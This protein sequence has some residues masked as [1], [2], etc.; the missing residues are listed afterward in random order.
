MKAPDATAID[1]PESTRPGIGSWFLL[2]VLVLLLLA[3][4]WVFF[5]A[6]T[7]VGNGVVPTSGYVAMAF[8]VGFSLTF[9]FGLMTLVFYSDRR[10]Y[11]EPPVMLS[12]ESRSQVTRGQ[13]ETGAAQ[14]TPHSM[15]EKDALPVG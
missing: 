7:S 10:G 3:T 6:W 4:V 5:V 15:E 13:A 9:G 8:G 12:H 11:D 1:L 14:L 2:A